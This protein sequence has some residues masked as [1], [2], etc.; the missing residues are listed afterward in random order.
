M[1]ARGLK[2]PVLVIFDGAPGL[3]KAVKRMWPRA[4]RQRCQVH[5]MRNILA[6]LPR[7]M[8]GPMKRLIHQVFRAPSYSLALKHGRALIARFHDRYP[9][10]MECLETIPYP[11]HLHMQ[12]R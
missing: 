11:E 6:K 2:A 9:A 4:F 5:K 12:R 7:L 1:V 3:N 10:A 8:Q